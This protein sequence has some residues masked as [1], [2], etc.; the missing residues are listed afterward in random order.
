[1]PVE[2]TLRSVH[3]QCSRVLSEMPFDNFTCKKRGGDGSWVE[4]E[5]GKYTTF[6]NFF[7]QKL[8]TLKIVAPPRGQCISLALG[9]VKGEIQMDLARKR[10][11]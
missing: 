7:V 5:T 1:M 6:G 10:K 11:T 2:K 4:W 3:E 8:P 9:R